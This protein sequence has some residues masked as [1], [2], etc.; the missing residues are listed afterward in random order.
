[1]PLTSLKP[2]C[3]GT[4]CTYSLP[5]HGRVSTGFMAQTSPGV[6]DRY[7]FEGPGQHR[8]EFFG[9]LDSGDW[10]NMTIR[11]DRP[12]WE[13]LSVFRPGSSFSGTLQAGDSICSWNQ[14]Y[15]LTMRM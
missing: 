5:N 2:L 12:G 4:A 10:L 6:I 3:A 1:M 13:P 11:S 14:K 7:D 8:T 9:V 15:T